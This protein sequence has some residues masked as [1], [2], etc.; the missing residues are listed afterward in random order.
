[1]AEN[2]EIHGKN[3]KNGALYTEIKVHRLEALRFKLLCVMTSM[4]Q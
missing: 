2:T 1:M 3:I 4:G